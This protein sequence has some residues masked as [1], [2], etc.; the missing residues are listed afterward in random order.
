M[1]WFTMTEPFRTA[2]GALSLLNEV[3]A[4]QSTAV[5]NLTEDDINHMLSSGFA[6]ELG[7]Q[8]RTGPTVRLF[9]VDEIHKSRR[10]VITWPR[11]SNEIERTRYESLPKVL[12]PR[13]DA[14]SAKAARRYAHL[15]D[16]TKYFQ[17]Y[18]MPQ[19]LSHLWCFSAGGRHFGLTTVP[20]GA[21]GPP[22]FGHVLVDSMCRWVIAEGTR[23]GGLTED[24]SIGYDA[25]IDNVRF[26]SN[27][28]QGLTTCSSLFTLAAA[29]LGVSIGEDSGITT[30]YDFLGLT[31]EHTAGFIT[32]SSRS[33][34]KLNTFAMLVDKGICSPTEFDKHYS[35]SVWLSLHMRVPLHPIYHIIK[36]YRK[37]IQPATKDKRYDP[38]RAKFDATVPIWRSI[39]TTLHL[40][41]Q[42]LKSH[43]RKVIDEDRQF[44][45]LHAY[46]DASAAG[47]GLVVLLEDRIWSAAGRW[48]EAEASLHINTLELLAVKQ[49][50]LRL[51]AVWKLV[52]E[53]YHGEM[54]NALR[55]HV[56]NSA[57]LSWV[58]KKRAKYYL[59]N[60]ILADIDE[61]EHA[62]LA[63]LGAQLLIVYEWVP[64]AAN[65]ADEASRTWSAK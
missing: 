36:F 55:V 19:Q 60:A 63:A 1:V 41:I 6:T 13:P 22:L 28:E 33:I 29:R 50:W 20:T 23:S 39:T 37:E 61:L 49:L 38:P 57:C 59:P 46:T 35:H 11:H 51:P 44:R 40:W 42:T 24:D 14:I 9:T 56:D 32:A 48:T 43:K 10:R 21:V 25:W 65:L 47:F 27:T 17:Q 53:S 58:R 5:S 30:S 45:L 54:P 64:S 12:F 3:P 15:Y 31:Y 62:F 4:H 18:A 52:Q 16:L 8:S 7:E 2:K 26:T 34:E